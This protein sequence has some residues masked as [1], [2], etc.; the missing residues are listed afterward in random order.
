MII[1]CAFVA[2]E[3]SLVL[4]NEGFPKFSGPNPIGKSCATVLVV[5]F[6]MSLFLFPVLGNMNTET[7]VGDANS[8]ITCRQGPQG[9]MA[10]LE[11]ETTATAT[12]AFFLIYSGPSSLTNFEIADRSAQIVG[13]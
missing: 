9:L 7:P 11:S 3:I 13:E 10:V 12:I 2:G 4:S 5:R 8:R 6:D 1:N